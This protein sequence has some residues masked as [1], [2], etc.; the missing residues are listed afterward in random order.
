[1]TKK[2]I[3]EK[4][5]RMTGTQARIALQCINEGKTMEEAI[6]IALTY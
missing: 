2:E 1:M 3:E 4:I 5:N 6:E